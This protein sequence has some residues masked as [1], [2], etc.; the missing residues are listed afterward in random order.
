MNA[1]SI[2]KD[3]IFVSISQAELAFLSN[4]INE[5]MESVEDWEFH[6]RT[7][8]TRKRAA[9]IQTEIQKILDEVR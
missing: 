3:Q 5:A 9:E 2:T 1:T 6:S 7:G 8:E 4:A